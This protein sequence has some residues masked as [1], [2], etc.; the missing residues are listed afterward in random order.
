MKKKCKGAG[1]KERIWNFDN[2]KMS[3]MIKM[4]SSNSIVNIALKDTKFIIDMFLQ[5]EISIYH[6]SVIKIRLNIIVEFVL[7]NE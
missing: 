3:S 5:I 1:E 2:W 7:C 6:L 4:F